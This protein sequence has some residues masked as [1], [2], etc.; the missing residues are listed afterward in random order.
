MSQYC[1]YDPVHRDY[2]YTQAWIDFLVKELG[3]PQRYTLLTAGRMP[4]ALPAAAGAGADGPQVP[5]EAQNAGLG[6]SAKM[7]T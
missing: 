3:D 4:M 1:V 7:A 6:T 5:P 2:V